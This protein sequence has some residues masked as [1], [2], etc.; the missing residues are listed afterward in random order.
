MY[1]KKDL[2]LIIAI[3]DIIKSEI[4]VIILNIIEELDDNCNVRCKTPRVM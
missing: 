1:R 4:I 3:R 2:V